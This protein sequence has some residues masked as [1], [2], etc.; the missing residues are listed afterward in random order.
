MRNG[1]RRS[2]LFAMSIFG[3]VCGEA[4]AQKNA[5]G[6]YGTV[7]DY[8]GDLNSNNFSLFNFKSYKPSLAVGVEQY[9][10]PTFNSVET[11]AYDWANYQ[12]DNKTAGVDAQFLSALLK[13]KLKL[14]NGYMF[15]EEARVRPFLDFGLGASYLKAHKFTNNT[16]STLF[17][18]GTH[19]AAA[20]GIG[21]TFPLTQIASFEIASHAYMPMSDDWDGLSWPNTDLWANDIHV[22]HSLGFVFNLN[23][24]GRGG[25]EDGDGV[26]DKRDRCPRT[27]RGTR[28]NY[29]GCAKD[30]DGDGL[31]DDEDKCPFVKGPLM[32][33]GCPDRDGDY[34]PDNEDACP[35][36]P[37]LVKNHG[38][39]DGN[40]QKLDGDED[41]DGVP[42]SRD[43]C[44]HTPKGRPVDYDG[45]P[46]GDD[47]T[48]TD[49]DGVPNRIDRCPNTPG[50]KWNRGCPEVKA[51]AKR[52]LK[53]ATRGIYYETGK[54]TIKPESYPMLDEIADI[55]KSYPDYALRIGGHTDIVG[56]D[57][58]NMALSQSRMESVRTYLIGK[59][60]SPDRLVGESYGKTRPVASNADAVGRAFNRRVEMELFLK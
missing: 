13:L 26:P 9:L 17:E 10:S 40:G 23:T 53:F 19:L 60:I 14:N 51:E 32:F 41:E 29:W 52:R 37:G 7:N 33:R 55:I 28:V 57:S 8:V 43:K 27:P 48:D 38:C 3:L 31:T 4:F 56:G 22:Q 59:G 36:V 39:P 54:A 6:F 15:R 45:C 46:Y 49:G 1:F 25:D 2:V 18:E 11:F 5:I 42:D 12:N 44:P 20:T 47:N 50:P 35:D 58:Y 34:V 16:S 24:V 21:F 30:T